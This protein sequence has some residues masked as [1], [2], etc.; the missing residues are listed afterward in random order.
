MK[1]RIS[2][3]RKLVREAVE[4]RRSMMMNGADSKPAQGALVLQHDDL[5]EITQCTMD[6]DCICDECMN[7][8]NEDI[9]DY[10]ASPSNSR[11]GINVADENDDVDEI[12][13]YG[14]KDTHDKNR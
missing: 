2:Q 9:T 10:V 14:G 12:I 7:M 3:L 11:M 6:E 8:Q 1:I 5:S 4:A 13:I